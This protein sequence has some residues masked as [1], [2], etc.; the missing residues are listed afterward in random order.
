MEDMSVAATAGPLSAW[1]DDHVRRAHRL[2]AA[3]VRAAL[4]GG[5][6]DDAELAA[7][8]EEAAL[9]GEELLRRGL[10]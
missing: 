6:A 4:S 3:A 8:A 10:I 9:F 1:P 2:S 5:R 7:A